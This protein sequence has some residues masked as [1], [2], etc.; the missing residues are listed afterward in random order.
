M[1]MTSEREIDQLVRAVHGRT[2]IGLA[3]GILMDRMDT[4]AA[5]AFDYPRRGSSHSNRK[6][7]DV[8][9]EIVRARKLPYLT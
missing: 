2:V 3:Q 6:L 8:A 9:D 1:V 7:V 5:P 4:D